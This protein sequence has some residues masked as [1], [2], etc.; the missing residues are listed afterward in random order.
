[1]SVGRPE[2]YSAERQLLFLI[3]LY[4]ISVRDVPGKLPCA[5]G[6]AGA[7]DLPIAALTSLR[8]LVSSLWEG[9]LAARHPEPRKPASPSC[10]W[11]VQ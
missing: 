2:A 11:P 7:V 4:M 10:S 5:F 6:A 3:S 1:M 8:A 9:D